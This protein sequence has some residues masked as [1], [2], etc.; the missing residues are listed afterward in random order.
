MINQPDE[1]NFPYHYQ[2]DGLKSFQITVNYKSGSPVNIK[3]AK[4]QLRNA[5]YLGYEFSED[6]N[7]MNISGN[8]I[9]IPTIDSW[10]ILPGRYQYDLEVIDSNDF[11]MTVLKGTWEVRKDITK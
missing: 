3:S 10:D 6:K 1:F 11:V 4:M 7:N 2:N 8:V 9:S 5:G